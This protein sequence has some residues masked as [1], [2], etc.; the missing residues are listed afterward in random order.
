[1]SSSRRASRLALALVLS[2][3]TLSASVAS[4][5][6]LPLA[7]RSAW[8]GLGTPP[9]GSVIDLAPAPGGVLYAVGTFQAIGGVSAGYLARWDGATWTSLG[10]A[11]DWVYAVAVAPDGD[12]YVGGRFTEIGGVQ[13][14]RVAR[15]DGAAWHA[16]GVGFNNPVEDL[17]FDAS[18]RLYAGGGFRIVGDNSGLGVAR[19]D[20]TAWSYV[21]GS[22]VDNTVSALA[23]D[24]D[25]L[26]VAGSFSSL[27]GVAASDVARFDDETG[28][29]ALGTGVTQVGGGH[30]VYALALDASGRLFAGGSFTE[31]GG[32]AANHLARWDGEAW[33]PVGGVSGSSGG[34][35]GVMALAFDGAGQLYVGGSFTEA[36]GVATKGVAMTDGAAWI[37]LGSGVANG[38]VETLF[39]A[40]D[41]PYLYVGGG[42][43]D[44]GGVAGLS[45]L[46]RWDGVTSTPAERGPEAGALRLTAPAPN[47]SARASTLWLTTASTADVRADLVDVTG[48]VVGVLYA[49]P[50]VAGVPLALRADRGDL[51]AGVYV[52]R[53]TGGGE[54][55]TRRVTFV[56]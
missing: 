54:R 14:S 38:R 6:D 5:T 8:T 49:G 35:T 3:L 10:D 28:V 25:T 24:G 9:G 27:G 16:V 19:W 2:S 45:F 41:R 23:T 37:A 11:N 31:I 51:P 12:V 36:G 48:R 1:M 22:G 33:A 46:A 21:G 56:R 44:M 47:P 32:Q 55:L 39:V 4:A 42:F 15:W 43:S 13:A 17:V 7:T 30:G 18:G 34:S 29:R 53:V 20:G 40:Q 50:V 52:V 26:Y